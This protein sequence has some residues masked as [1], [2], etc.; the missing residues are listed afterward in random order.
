MNFRLHKLLVSQRAD[1]GPSTTCIRKEARTC[2]TDNIF[3]S[4][5]LLHGGGSMDTSNSSKIMNT[6]NDSNS[7][8][9][10]HNSNNNNSNA[11]NASRMSTASLR[12]AQVR[13]LAGS[14]LHHQASLGEMNRSS[15]ASWIDCLQDDKQL[16]ATASFNVTAESIV[17]R[18]AEHARTYFADEHLVST[19][20]GILSV[21]QPNC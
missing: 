16:L 21:L 4:R 1:A 6:D 18:F 14:T 12:R 17:S 5:H 15:T 20:P 3:D 9:N 19:R 7:N 10:H 11:S 8:N 13:G 2:R